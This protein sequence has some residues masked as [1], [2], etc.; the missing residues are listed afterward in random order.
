MRIWQTTLLSLAAVALVSGPAVASEKTDVMALV[1]QFVDAF[2]KGDTKSAIAACAD[3]ASIIDDVPPYEWHGA[4]ACSR[5]FDAY[6]ADARKNGITDGFVTLGKARHINVSEGHAYVLISL[7]YVFKR[8]GIEVREIGAKLTI[9]LQKQ[10]AGWR[11]A[12]WAY[13]KP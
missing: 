7:D 12:G 9:A 3:E 1:H 2:N 8:K 6:D 10:P 13:A 11:I 4:H 5:W